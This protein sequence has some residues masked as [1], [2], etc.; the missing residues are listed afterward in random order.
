MHFA[1]TTDL[2][3]NLILSKEGL[4]PESNTTGTAFC[5]VT[6]EETFVL[7][8]T[9]TSILLKTM[10]FPYVPNKGIRFVPY[11]AQGQSLFALTESRV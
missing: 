11:S 8:C 3:E 7:I 6:Y 10:V 1:I 2:D 5:Q 4:F 9:V